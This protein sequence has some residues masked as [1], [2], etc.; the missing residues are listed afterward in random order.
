[1]S[2]RAVAVGLVLVLIVSV[3]VGFV[4]YSPRGTE[5][6][7]T[8]D[9]TAPVA[10][11]ATP[12][13]PIIYVHS[14]NAARTLTDQFYTGTYSGPYT[15]PPLASH[16][17]VNT[18]LFTVFDNAGDKTVNLTLN[19][20]NAT[21]DGLTNPVLTA[22][23]AINQTTDLSLFG[24]N[25]VSYTFPGSIVFG[26]QWN[27]TVSAP[28]AGTAVED[29][30]LHTFGLGAASVPADRSSVLPGET[31]TLNWWAISVV[32]G[33]SFNSL[34][35]LTLWGSYFNGTFQPLFSPG[36]LPLPTTA[37][38]TTT[39]TVPDNATSGSTMYFNVSA[40]TNSSGSI[41]ENETVHFMLYVGA[42]DIYFN[43]ASGCTDSEQDNFYSGTIIYVNVEAGA[44][45]VPGGFAGESGLP[46]GISFTN[47]LTPVLPGGSPP[48]TLT[49]GPAG[50]VCFS[51]Q[52]NA[53]PFQL[54]TSYP[55]ANSVNLTLADPSATG[56]GEWMTWDNLTFTLSA[57]GLEG[58][59]AVQLNANVY[60]VGQT[61]TVTWSLGAANASVGTLT[62]QTWSLSGWS[63]SIYA[64]G[65]IT[66]TAA[67]GTFTVALPTDLIGTFVVTV[68]AANATASF[69]G[70]AYATVEQTAILVTGGGYYTAGASLSWN[71][72][73]SPAALPGTTTTFEIEAYWYD[74]FDDYMGSALVASGTLGSS[75]TISYV[76]P[77]GA[78][79]AG[80]IDVSVSAQTP[81][82]GVY[83]TGFGYAELET[84]YYVQLG[85]STPSNYADGSYQPG[86]TIQV[87]WAVTSYGGEAVPS[88]LYVDIYLGTVGTY[89]GS[90]TQD[91][92]TWFDTTSTSGSVP[93]TLPSNLPSGGTSISA[94]V[95]AYGLV[96]G[97]SCEEENVTYG[98]CFNS[99]TV[100]INAHPSVLS[101]ELGAGSGITVGWLILLIVIA[102]VAILL[103]LVIRRGQNPKSPP[104]G[105][106]ASQP[107]SP[108]APAPSSPP[109]A[110]WQGN[111]TPPEPAASGDAPPPLPTPPSDPQ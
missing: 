57:G 14:W 44:Y 98:A 82:A 45:S 46:I 78:S 16:P 80:Y 65:A 75:D 39:F 49:S 93:F 102:V 33:G 41:G 101:M 6:S 48:T 73:F 19:D 100:N 27:V 85:V 95:S 108:P 70:T 74:Q 36:L 11:A 31:V 26:G 91:T 69:Y 15:A 58:G 110:E 97:P 1:M 111:P 24:Q 13:V 47:G 30:T 21:R 43:T 62:A 71:V 34:T 4:A 89:Y 67:T 66:S 104:T 61:A 96:N 94:W 72:Q 79:A 40:V 77:S 88:L 10:T 84:G 28:A 53:P 25:G 23:V 50:L 38:G 32:N 103:F 51:F 18:I 106:T 76:V 37:S 55:F 105:Y 90:L 92:G 63:G 17:G 7:S 52:G 86:Q 59:V 83:A 109:A 3:L 29:L 87:T 107:M 35:S 12:A 99:I 20:P 81:T 60:A 9:A 56:L 5:S 42:P 64:T 22:S 8:R 54:E 68:V 2:R